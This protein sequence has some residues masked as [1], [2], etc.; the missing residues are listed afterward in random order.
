MYGPSNIGENRENIFDF[1]RDKLDRSANVTILV[2][3]YQSF[4][5]ITNTKI[6]DSQIS[7]R[8]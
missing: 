3:S 5:L 6:V 4:E 2:L 1:E 7:K 8:K